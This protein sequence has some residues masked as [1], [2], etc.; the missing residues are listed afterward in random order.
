MKTSFKVPPRKRSRLGGLRIRVV[1]GDGDANVISLPKLVYV[2]RGDVF[3]IIGA[4]HVIDLSIWSIT[5]KYWNL[6]SCQLLPPNYLPRCF[7][8]LDDEDHYTKITVYF[9]FLLVLS[10]CND[11]SHQFFSIID[12]IKSVQH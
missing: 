2:S 1:R 5:H 9:D 6:I 8:R 7:T 4:L 12:N 10:L 11:S 3:C